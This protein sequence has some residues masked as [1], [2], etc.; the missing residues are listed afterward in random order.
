MKY[1]QSE[2]LSSKAKNLN[3][4]FS[5]NQRLAADVDFQNVVHPF[6]SFSE[7]TSGRTVNN[8]YQMRF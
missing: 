8:Y 7:E 4:R 1:Y 2:M 6:N 3:L 5:V